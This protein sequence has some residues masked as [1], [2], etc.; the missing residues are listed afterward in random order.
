M[1]LGASKM[2][3]QFAIRLSHQVISRA[4][5]QPNLIM[6]AKRAIKPYN[7][8]SAAQTAT[9]ASLAYYVLTFLELP[10]VEAWSIASFRV[11]GMNFSTF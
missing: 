1:Q 5:A 2:I 11:V 6:C 10:E 3:F 7:P 9:S 8:R 4:C